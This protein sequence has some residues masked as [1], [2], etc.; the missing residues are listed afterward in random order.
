MV[1]CIFNAYASNSTT[2]LTRMSSLFTYGDNFGIIL[3]NCYIKQFRP[4]TKRQRRRKR[5]YM[6][7]I[8]SAKKRVRVTSVKSTLN[9]KTKKIMRTSMKSFN[10][11]VVEGKNV[12]DA[13]AKAQSALDIAVKKG[14]I[15]KN[16]AAR[17]KSQLN[18]AAKE[19]NGGK[20]TVAPKKK[21]PAA[22]K[23]AAAKKPAVKK[24]A[25]KKAAK[26]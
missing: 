17:K 1:F 6:P 16:K 19:A 12:D 21:A 11:A 9:A 20:K 7:I 2:F 23:P 5:S 3:T 25:T 15:S 13:Q 14:I 10:T 22:A 18:K 8:K 24:P 26:K 4:Q